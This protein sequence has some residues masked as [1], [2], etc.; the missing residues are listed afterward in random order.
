M[1]MPFRFEIDNTDLTK[2]NVT[3]NSTSR[4]V[5][6]FREEVIE[7]VKYINDNTDRP[8]YV[9]LSGGIDSDVIVRA[10]LEA[11]IDFTVFTVV[12]TEG[13]NKHDIVYANQLIDKYKIKRVAVN[14]EARKFFDFG[15]NLYKNSGYISRNI[16]RY[17]QL[18]ILDEITKLGG[19]AVL[20]GGDASGYCNID[21]KVCFRWNRDYAV[22]L[23]W[24]ERNNIQHYPYFYLTTPEITASWLEHPLVKL[25]TSDPAYFKSQRFGYIAEK[26]LV[27]HRDW[28]DMPR[29]IKF[30]G[31][32]KISDIRIPVENILKDELPDTYCAIPIDI[33]RKQLGI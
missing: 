18:F 9:A 7:T 25:L 22:P 32:E 31:F 20:G 5:L 27:L 17:L 2:F 28:K 6:T 13:T 3:L 19:C 16:F 15:F 23:Q 8:I 11:N 1:L 4:P 29:R 26:A 33:M 24:I 12:H 14:L 21:D 30:N 10:F